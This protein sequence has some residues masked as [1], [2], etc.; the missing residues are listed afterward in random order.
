MRRLLLI[1]VCVSGI[2][3]GKMPV[4]PNIVLYFAD[5]ISAREFPIYGTPQW[6]PPERGDTSNPEYRA[7][8][9]VL[10]KLAEQGCWITSA[11]AATLCKPSRAMLL[12]GRYAHR[13]TWWSN[14]DIGKVKKAGGWNEAYHIYDS[15]PILL[16]HVAG[17]AGYATYWAGKFHLSGD[18]SKYGFDEAMITPGLL[19]E[20][21]NPYSDFQ[22]DPQTLN[23]KRVLINMDT[24]KP[25][26]KKTYAQDSWYWQPNVRLWNNPSAPG[27]LVWWP[28]TPKAKKNFG[29]HTYGPDLEMEFIFDFIDRRKDEAK[30][31]FIYHASH[32]GHDQFDFLDSRSTSSWPGTPKIHWDGRRYTR[33]EPKIT[34]DKGVYDTHGTVTEPGMHSHINYIDFQIWQYLQKFEEMDILDNTVFIITADNGSGGYGKNSPD[35]QKGCHV[36]MIIYAPGMTKQG[37]Q[38]IMAGIVDLWPTIAELTGFEIPEN[39]VYDGVSMVPFLFGDKQTHRDWVYTYQER[40]QIIRGHHVMRDGNNRWWDVSSEPE[41]YNT[42]PEIKDWDRVSEVHQ[43]EREKLLTILPEYE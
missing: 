30:P 36:P 27:K 21:T 16:S 8:T 19:A 39:Y 23:G 7:R 33:T 10:D 3:L 25:I 15:T 28:N 26:E 35:H 6:S 43:A 18:Y 32:L 14:R 42:Y 12:T 9:P 5:D 34:G 22:L 40:N 41:D 38:D 2:T 31:F 4:K 37:R 20:P 29:R 24:G 1:S 17:Q 11:W 13:Q